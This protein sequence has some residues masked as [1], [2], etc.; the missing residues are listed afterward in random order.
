MRRE[1]KKKSG[2]RKQKEEK[3]FQNIREKSYKYL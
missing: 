3:N 2:R 1:G